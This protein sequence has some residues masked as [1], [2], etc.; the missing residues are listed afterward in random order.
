MLKIYFNENLINNYPH[1]PFLSPILWI[2]DN[3]GENSF[4]KDLIREWEELWKKYLKPTMIE[5]CDYV[6]FPKNF[7]VDFMDELLSEN[8]EAKK[9][10]KKMIVFYHHDNEI[11]IDDPNII[12]FRTSVSKKAS[13]N[14]CCYPPIIESI[15]NEKLSKIKNCK[16]SIW[17]TCYFERPSFLLKILNFIRIHFSLDNFL[18]KVSVFL[19]FFIPD[20]VCAK[21]WIN[22]VT[23]R[24]SFLYLMVQKWKWKQIRYRVIKYIQEL[25][26]PFLFIK[27]ERMLDPL[28]KWNYRE[29]YINNIYSC[30]FPLVVR[31]DWNYSYRLYEVMSAGK[32]P[33]FIDT[34]SKLPFE[35]EINYKNLFIRIPYYDVKNI[36]QYI[37][38]Y[39]AINKDLRV[40]EDKIRKCYEEYL[41][42]PSWCTR[43]INILESQ[44]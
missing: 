38:N 3:N 11:S 21:F 33:L 16:N 4:W 27:R 43:I 41:R 40:V 29:E 31:W 1:V 12:L 34:W 14:E 2:F 37:K 32:I 39:L 23:K 6:V 44:K 42:F 7:A 13:V 35:N 20:S 18:Y 28:V 8:K 19:S 22:P 9:Y 10:W 25:D 15:Y 17:Y 5:D 36:W 24:D 30:E 26:Y